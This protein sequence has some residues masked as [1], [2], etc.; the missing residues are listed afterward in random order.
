MWDTPV[1]RLEPYVK[2]QQRQLLFREAVLAFMG[3]GSQTEAQNPAVKA[4]C[5]TCKAA[6]LADCDNCDP[7]QIRP[8]EGAG[9]G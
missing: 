5:A 3:A 4:Y 6:G 8:D 9:N 1:M 2:Y 7:S